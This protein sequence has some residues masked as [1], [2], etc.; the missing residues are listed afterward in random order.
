[1]IKSELAQRVTSQNL[2]L[3]Q[4]D[5]EKIVDALLNHII[6]AMASGDRVELGLSSGVSASVKTREARTGIN[7]R[8]RLP[9]QVSRKVVPV[10]KTGKEMRERLNSDR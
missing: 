3:R 7:P 1:M 2:H 5:A 6:D 10:F 9:V 8:T 4:R